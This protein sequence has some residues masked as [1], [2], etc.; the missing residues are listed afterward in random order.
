MRFHLN[1]GRTNAVKTRPGLGGDTVGLQKPP[2]EYKGKIPQYLW[3][4]YGT[5]PSQHRGNTVPPPFPLVRGSWAFRSVQ[6]TRKQVGIAGFRGKPFGVTFARLRY[7][8]GPRK[9]KGK[10]SAYDQLQLELKA[11]RKSVV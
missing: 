5:T 1:S 11:D 3:S 9:R 8:L 7:M 4:T 2:R 10:M 6:D